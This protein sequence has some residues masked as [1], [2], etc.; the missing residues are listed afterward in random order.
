MNKWSKY[1]ANTRDY[2]YH[3]TLLDGI[4][5]GT[6]LHGFIPCNKM[7]AG[8][9]EYKVFDVF[10]AFRLMDADGSKWDTSISK[11]IEFINKNHEIVF[12]WVQATEVDETGAKPIE[13]HLIVKMPEVAIKWPHYLNKTAHECVLGTYYV[14]MYYTGAS[15]GYP[16]ITFWQ[17][18]EWIDGS[19]YYV[20][21]QHPHISNGAACWGD[22]K[23]NSF[24][25]MKA[26]N[27]L[28]ALIA[29][30]IFLNT[31]NKESPYAP[32]ESWQ[33]EFHVF[34]LIGIHMFQIGEADIEMD[35]IVVPRAGGAMLDDEEM[36]MN[37]L[38]EIKRSEGPDACIFLQEG[39]SVMHVRPNYGMTYQE[40]QYIHGMSMFPQLL[41]LTVRLVLYH[42]LSWMRAFFI[43]IKAAYC[44]WKAS[45]ASAPKR[46]PQGV[47]KKSAFNI[48]RSWAQRPDESSYYQ[49]PGFYRWTWS[50]RMDGTRLE[51][52]SS[53]DMHLADIRNFISDIDAIRGRSCSFNLTGHNHSGA[54]LGER[55]RH[56]ISDPDY[57]LGFKEYTEGEFALPNTQNKKLICKKLREDINALDGLYQNA[58]YKQN[59]RFIEIINQEKELIQNEAN[60]Y[61]PVATKDKLPFESL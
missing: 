13:A 11:Q 27:V 60:N 52:V 49:L 29:T 48:L 56:K 39:L 18:L 57:I 16:S 61:C 14:D 28:A 21:A 59:K 5:A 2:G 53:E 19:D 23:T 42:N 41:P 17:K 34:R 36:A 4:L 31:Y 55:I 8:E 12:A 32:M 35:R 30:R 3:R 54:A 37:R 6:R 58:K 15:R 9:E 20:R 40:Q 1:V 45:M 44:E 7:L 51:K 46:W 26:G 43:A 10:D 25:P 24:D 47:I 33:S 38:D 50:S 22:M